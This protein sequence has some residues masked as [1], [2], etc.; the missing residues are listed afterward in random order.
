MT[1][2]MEDEQNLDTGL[3]TILFI[4]LTIF[5]ETAWFFWTEIVC[6]SSA[7]SEYIYCVPTTLQ[8]PHD[9]LR[10]YLELFEL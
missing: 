7:Y 4:V 6:H 9:G 1:Q 10:I 2:W 8:D 5:N 3:R